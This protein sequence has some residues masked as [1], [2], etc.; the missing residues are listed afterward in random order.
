MGQKLTYK[1][2]GDPGGLGAGN[3]DEDLPKIPDLEKTISNPEFWNK[4]QNQEPEDSE[5]E[6]KPKEASVPS[7]LT[8]KLTRKSLKENDFLKKQPEPLEFKDWKG[9]KIKF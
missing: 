6:L 8:Y 5:D 2:P 9:D 4:V 3:I 1:Q 7:P